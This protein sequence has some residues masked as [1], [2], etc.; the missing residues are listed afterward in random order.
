MNL[1]IDGTDPNTLDTIP[2]FDDPPLVFT[3]D[4]TSGKELPYA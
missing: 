2:C 4:I 3:A 1:L